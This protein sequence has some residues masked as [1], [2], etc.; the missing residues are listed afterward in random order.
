MSLEQTKEKKFL[1]LIIV[2]SVAIPL[3]VAFL[4]YGPKGEISGL[5]KGTLPAFNAFV[6]A[7]TSVVLVL[8]FVAIKNKKVALHKKLMQSALVLSL[9]FLLSYVLHHATA[10]STIYGGEG[11]VK[12]IYLFI[13]LTHI[14]LAAVIVPLVL[15]SYVR[16][17]SERFDK[18]RKIAKITLPLWLYVTVTGVIVYFMISPY[19]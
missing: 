2:A 9:V 6:N 18:H 8:A 16:A 3:V 10:E 12:T 17:I 13:L 5:E 11:A 4:Y 7:L 14:V 19:Y 15:I 1:P